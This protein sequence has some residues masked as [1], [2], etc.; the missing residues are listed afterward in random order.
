[1]DDATNYPSV[2][3]IKAPNRPWTSE[4]WMETRNKKGQRLKKS[5]E[6]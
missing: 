6:S 4:K 3:L 1:M 2:T 5:G